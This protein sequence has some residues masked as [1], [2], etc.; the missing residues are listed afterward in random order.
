[1]EIHDDFLKKAKKQFIN[2][3]RPHS[4]LYIDL[5]LNV[6]LW[7]VFCFVFLEKSRQ[8]QQLKLN[9]KTWKTFPPSTD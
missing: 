3:R 8:F 4:V 5:H 2:N 7:C 6:E 9:F 1:M